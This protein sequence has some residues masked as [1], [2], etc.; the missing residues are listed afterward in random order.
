M[1]S[2]ETY[3]EDRKKVG[4]CHPQTYEEHYMRIFVKDEHKFEA[5]KF[6]FEQTCKKFSS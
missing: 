5:A 3:Y 1:I 6:A 4:L 2:I